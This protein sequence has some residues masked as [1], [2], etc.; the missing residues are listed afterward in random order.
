[1]RRARWWACAGALAVVLAGCVESPPACDG[2]TFYRPG[3]HGGECVSW[4]P[5]AWRDSV[6][7]ILDAVEPLLPVL[8]QA[9]EDTLP[10]AV[11]DRLESPRALRD[12]EEGFPRIP[13]EIPA[14]DAPGHHE[15]GFYAD[16]AV[17]ELRYGLELLT[18]V[19]RAGGDFAREIGW[20]RYHLRQGL[21]SHR[22]A[23]V[24][25]EAVPRIDEPLPVRRELQRGPGGDGSETSGAGT[26]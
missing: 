11:R 17:A 12:A 5:A 6:R 26:L 15:L 3:P 7:Q 14:R 25:L 8:A 4:S 19:E 13:Y 18:G 23:R 20:G 24:L 1:M 2:P 16:E 9:A 10:L 21:R 22:R